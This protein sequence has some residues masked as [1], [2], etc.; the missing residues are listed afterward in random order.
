MNGRRSDDFIGTSEVGIRP[1]AASQ[2][3]TASVI[4]RAMREAANAYSSGR[5]SVAEQLANAILARDSARFDALNLLGVIAAQTRRLPEAADLLRRA[6]K[7]RPTD[8]AAHNNYANVLKALQRDDEALKSYDRA[9]KLDPRN[10]EAHHNRGVVLQGLGHLEEACRSYERATRAQPQYFDAHTNLAGAQMLLGRLSDANDSADRAIRINPRNAIAHY[11]RG[12]IL[13]SLGKPAEALAAFRT[14]LQLRAE[15]PEAHYGCGNVLYGMQRYEE[16]LDEYDRAVDIR[17]AYPEAHCNRGNVLRLLNRT[18]EALAC[19]ERAL[20]IDP[21]QA[22]A[23]TN[24]G[25]ALKSMGKLES[26]EVSYGNAIAVA[27][28]SIDAHFGRGIVLKE[29][30]RLE[31]ALGC[32][33]RALQLNPGFAE[34]LFNR[35]LVCK[36]LGWLDQALNAFD[37]A[38]M[39]QP[40]FVD[41][42]NSRGNTLQS[43]RRCEEALESYDRALAIDPG[44]ANAWNN[45]GNALQQLRRFAEALASFDKALQLLPDYSNAWNNRGLA[46]AKLDRPKEAIA[47]YDRAIWHASDCVDAYVN[48]G[49]ALKELRSFGA[50]VLDYERA[51]ELQ[52]EYEW[53]YGNW[54]YTRME[55]CDWREWHA[56]VTELKARI[57]EDKKC[58]SPF[59]V[60]SLV[61]EP[62]LQRRATETWV[63]HIHPEMTL[64]GPLREGP[65]T[66]RIRVGYFSADFR[67][68][69]VSTLIV[70]LLES[71]D[72]SRFEVIAFSMSA[73][74]DAMRDRIERAVERFVDVTAMSDRE[75]ALLARDSALD[76]AIDLGGFTDGAR[77]GIFAL[78]AAPVQVSYLGYL[79]TMGGSYMDYIFAD[80]LIIP[81][82]QRA[83][84]AEKIAYL[85]HY[86]AN[87]PT[88]EMGTA[89]ASRES[90]GLPASGFV[91]CC[92]NACYKITPAT[93]DSWMRILIRVPGSV[94]L[95]LSDNPLVQGN[96][97]RE[98][99][100]RDVAPERL[101]FCGRVDFAE[102]LSRYR[103]ADLFLDTH[104]YNA[105]TTASD[106]L[107]AGL[108]VLTYAGTSFASRM[109]SSIL[110]AVGLPE[111]VAESREQYERLAVE[112]GRDSKRLAGI[113][114]RLAESR[115]SSPL[116]DS[117]K[118]AA[119]VEFAYVRM[120][121]RHRAG[122]P[123]DHIRAN[124]T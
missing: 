36:E 34:A 98:A 28:D 69:P 75:I 51:L 109:A 121:E 6:V 5:W 115:L 119:D 120:I 94:L 122:Q 4:E 80:D 86:Q 46:L 18:D 29:L 19:Y 77:P 63:A 31:E 55:I 118:A 65:A 74:R 79:G 124:N 111:L 12:N 112:I 41:A 83:N 88:R 105:G 91:Y 102:Y 13:Q 52:P 108:P 49:H 27:T 40:D 33:D 23:W 32:F 43:L 48:R 92:L 78:R 99:E 20:Q 106:A 35:G 107:W 25:N 101:V 14:A 50:A 44:C 117:Q 103:V 47:H 90:Y 30:G 39:L 38:L 26:A 17:E 61:D 89:A 70:G 3:N 9:L 114:A 64:L 68:H 58:T 85:P 97:R 7:S 123:P 95:L 53:L 57:A 54:L 24:Q 100:S 1:N 2:L 110:S 82:E 16:A 71:H 8:A 37:K 104:P 72:R 84:Y 42:H 22:N 56:H 113:R 73:Q 60:L 96:L 15:F 87:S 11:N 45:R 10:A 67:E 21:K 93:F 116:F 66:E 62:E 81:P 59:P 76:I